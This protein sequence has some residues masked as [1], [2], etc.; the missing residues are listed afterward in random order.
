MWHAV[1]SRGALVLAVGPAC[2]YETQ[3]RPGPAGS[4]V[5]CPVLCRAWHLLSWLSSLSE[6]LCPRLSTSWPGAP[7]GRGCVLLV[8][9]HSAQGRGVEEDQE[10]R[11]AGGRTGRETQRGMRK[12]GSCRVLRVT[13]RPGEMGS[14]VG[15]KGSDK[16][17]SKKW[18][19][20][21]MDL[22]PSVG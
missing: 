6:F 5:S 2:A 11:P 17:P 18:S 15:G 22:C 21:I 19:H 9:E 7:R 12:Q 8:F 20:L 4:S 16:Q 13:L 10:G 14:P 1:G 3:G